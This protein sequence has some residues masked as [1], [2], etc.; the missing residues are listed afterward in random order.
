MQPSPRIGPGVRNAVAIRDTASIPRSRLHLP[1]VTAEMKSLEIGR[2]FTSDSRDGDD[3]AASGWKSL[4][5]SRRRI[6]WL[7][8]QSGVLRPQVRRVRPCRVWLDCREF[9]V[10]E[11]LDPPPSALGK[12][13]NP[14]S[15][16]G[17][18]CPA[19]D[20]LHSCRAAWSGLRDHGEFN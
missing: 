4:S 18:H 3:G 19:R 6:L 5:N 10:R 16:A 2:R 8:Q 1:F 15:G 11:W 13:N 20:L 14:L 9:S 7:Y 17:A 12:Q